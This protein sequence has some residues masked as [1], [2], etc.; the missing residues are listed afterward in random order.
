[1]FICFY[2]CFSYTCSRRPT[3]R[4]IDRTLSFQ[5]IHV[6]WSQCNRFRFLIL[7]RFVCM[8][9]FFISFH[10]LI[11]CM[12]TMAAFHHSFN[13]EM[14]SFVY[15]ILQPYRHMHTPRR[16]KKPLCISIY[17][18]IFFFLRC[19]N[20][21]LPSREKQTFLCILKDVESQILPLWPRVNRGFFW[22]KFSF[23]FEFFKTFG[24]SL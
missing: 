3:N 6:W 18:Y 24:G 16:Y 4:S 7:F 23:R 20:N 8:F 19:Q 12:R 10:E 1:M 21:Y 9:L 17:G 22:L 15:A 13:R 2:Y 5:Y 11:L 14:Q